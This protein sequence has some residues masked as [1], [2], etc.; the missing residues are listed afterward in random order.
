MG[1]LVRQIMGSLDVHGR[2][3]GVGVGGI[4]RGGAH[5]TLLELLEGGRGSLGSLDELELRLGAVGALRLRH[6]ERRR[7]LFLEVLSQG[8]KES[9]AGF[10]CDV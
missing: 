7:S 10:G 8:E 6:L 1:E 2:R 4:Y 3:A 9:P 5:T